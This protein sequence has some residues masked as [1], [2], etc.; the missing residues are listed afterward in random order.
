MSVAPGMGAAAT[1]EVTVPEMLAMSFS[2]AV[3]GVDEA[4]GWSPIE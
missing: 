2:Y 3:V 1:V 4:A